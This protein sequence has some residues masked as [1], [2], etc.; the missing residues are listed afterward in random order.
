MLQLLIR[1]N[2]TFQILVM[3][4]DMTNTWTEGD[5]ATR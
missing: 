5:E 2:I 4:V 1:K 3:Q